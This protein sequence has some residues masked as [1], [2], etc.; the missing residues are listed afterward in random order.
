MAEKPIQGNANVDFVRATQSSNGSWTFNVTVSHHDT[1]W[2]DYADGWDVVTE[3]GVV[4]KLSQNSPFTRLLV[5]PHVDEQPFTRSQS[6]IILPEGT[7]KI[8]V[9]AHELKNGYG[10]KEVVIDLE[11]PIGPDYELNFFQ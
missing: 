1:G 3:D 2:E 10:G 6:G 11:V 8:I 4:I 9:R 7:K 5:H